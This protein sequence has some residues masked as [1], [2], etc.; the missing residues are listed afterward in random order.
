MSICVRIG[1]G[2]AMPRYKGN[3]RQN[4][5]VPV[6]LKD[7]LIPGTIEHAIDWIIDHEVDSSG[8]DALYGNDETGRPA[9]DPKALLKIILYAYSKGM[10]SSRRIEQACRTNVVFM[11]LSGGPSDADTARGRPL[12]HQDGDA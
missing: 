8:F 11:A 3:E 1:V 7:Q 2:G 9:Y 12:G 4:L 5:M 6:D 10:L